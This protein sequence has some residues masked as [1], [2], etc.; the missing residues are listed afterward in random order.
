[1]F[2]ELSLS[3]DNHSSG[4]LGTGDDLGLVLLPQGKRPEPIGLVGLAFFAGLFIVYPTYL[5]QRRVLP[6]LPTLSPDQD[7]DLL[8]LSTT[9]VAGLVEEM[10]KFGVVLLLFFWRKEMDEPV[11][12]LIYAMTVAMGFTAGEDFIRHIHGVEWARLLNPPGHAMFSALWGY[13]LGLYLVNERWQ[14]LLARLVLAVLVHGFWDALSI[15][16]ELEGRWWVSLVVF[17]LAFGL[18]WA[19]ECKLRHLQDPAFAE[20]FRTTRERWRQLTGQ[21]PPKQ[22]AFAIPSDSP[23]KMIPQKRGNDDSDTRV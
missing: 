6:H 16:R 7:F 2:V 19:M 14:P 20:R 11:D 5:L 1:M 12:G 3:Y 15:Y 10:A 9:I 4:S 23:Q 22:L 17:G 13:G 21:T 18:F 8:L